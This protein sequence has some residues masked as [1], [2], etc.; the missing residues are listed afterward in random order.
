MMRRRYFSALMFTA[1]LGFGSPPGEN[2]AR[3]VKEKKKAGNAEE[4][5]GAGPSEEEKK[6]S[7]GDEGDN[8]RGEKI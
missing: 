7:G 1:V 3:E 6:G 8:H 4:G 5:E 2:M